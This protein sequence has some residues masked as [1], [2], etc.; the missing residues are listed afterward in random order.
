MRHTT[1]RK[2]CDIGRTEKTESDPAKEMKMMT[3]SARI[4]ARLGL[5]AAR[6]SSPP[7]VVFEQG[8]RCD[9]R[10][11]LHRCYDTYAL[12]LRLACVLITLALGDTV[13][14]HFHRPTLD[15]VL[16]LLARR[17]ACF[18]RTAGTRTAPRVSSFFLV[19]AKALRCQGP[20]FESSWIRV[21]RRVPFTRTKWQKIC[22]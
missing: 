14:A 12:S 7:R 4:T 1:I 3:A 13:C 19:C 11:P 16:V 9:P 18:E 10:I 22:A 17:P 5:I 8:R 21:F 2:M 15:I 20:R 6:I